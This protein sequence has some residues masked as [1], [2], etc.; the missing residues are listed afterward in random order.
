MGEAD[1]LIRNDGNSDN[2]EREDLPTGAVKKLKQFMHRE[3]TFL[4]T[5]SREDIRLVYTFTSNFGSGSFGSVRIA[6]KTAVSPD[7]SFA[8]KSIR[9]EIIEESW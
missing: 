7:I 4:N 1:E 6:H 5:I 9:R 3:D 2:L 8:V